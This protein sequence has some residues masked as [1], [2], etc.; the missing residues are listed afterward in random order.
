MYLQ[1]GKT[2]KFLSTLLLLS[3]ILSFFAGF[4][5]AVSATSGD[6]VIDLDDFDDGQ[7]DGSSSGDD[8]LPISIF[9]DDKYWFHEGIRSEG[10][11]PGAKNSVEKTLT[12][13]TE[14]ELGLLAYELYQSNFYADYGWADLD[15]TGWTLKIGNDL[16]LEDHL[17]FPVN[18]GDF[19][20][21]ENKEIV[22]HNY[23]ITFDGQGHTISG[24]RVENAETT[25]LDTVNGQH[26][27]STGMFG[28]LDRSTIC[29]LVLKNP[30]ISYFTFGSSG[31]IHMGMLAGIAFGAQIR[32]VAIDNPII[33][34]DELGSE[35]II[36]SVVGYAHSCDASL[37]YTIGSSLPLNVTI[38]NGVDVY[39]RG[40]EGGLIVGKMN[41][42]SKPYIGGVAGISYN[43][44]ITSCAVFDLPIN[45]NADPLPPTYNICVGGIVGY[46]SMTEE[47]LTGV[48]LLNN[49][50]SRPNITFNDGNEFP[51]SSNERVNVG[52]LAGYIYN[53]SVVN[54]LY[55]GD[56]YWDDSDGAGDGFTT[57]AD[58]NYLYGMFGTVEY[59]E[60][61]FVFSHN[62]SFA[63]CYEEADSNAWDYG[64]G[65]GALY[66]VL[67]GA[68]KSSAAAVTAEHSG[69]ALEQALATFRNWKTGD[70][71]DGSPAV[72]EQ[73][74]YL[75]P[76]QAPFLTREAVEDP[77]PNPTAPTISGSMAM[78]LTEGYE[79][80]STDAYV[81][82]GSGTVTM[83]KTSGDPAI[84][85]NDT[86]KK[87]DIAAGLP[88]GSYL[89]ELKASN[90]TE[91]DATLS[92]TLTIVAANTAPTISGS[93]AMS[94]TE[95]Y[96][97]TSTD[98]YVITGSGTVTMEK[99]SGDSAITWNDST[100]RLD[101]AA[102]LPV[103][104]YLVELKASNGTEP[105]ATLAFTLTVRERTSG[106]GGGGLSLDVKY[107]ANSGA[108]IMYGDSVSSGS[109]YYIRANS[110]TRDGYVF[111]GWNTNA[112]GNGTYYADRGMINSLSQNVELFAQWTAVQT[113]VQP[114]GDPETEEQKE[115]ED[116]QEYS[117]DGTTSGQTPANTETMEWVDEEVPLAALPK[118]GDN[119]ASFCLLMVF[120]IYLVW[121]GS[122][123]LRQY[124]NARRLN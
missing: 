19:R 103:G 37:S 47:I 43:S 80:T 121:M 111:A 11:A 23:N 99:I 15:Y 86:T 95:G 52:G 7:W 116:I 71:P 73:V 104:S 48:C 78:S 60:A 12:I 5:L 39:G 91:P 8:D 35:A 1:I 10:Y 118:T 62:Y 42:G 81:I 45:L 119:N 82:T 30:L 120:A 36:G 76:Y 88:V 53:D 58:N 117:Q 57:D 92:F 85:W 123:W 93:M 77:V 54:N 113:A 20:E 33:K 101:I 110:F 18:L 34:I 3:M 56:L 61:G 69:Y 26:Y 98:A 89:V 64:A 38:I 40:D 6:S 55:F 90:G 44:V 107:N 9:A 14:A 79:A 74:E 49:L 2:R 24:L 102:G 115:D 112:D 59:D 46:S 22:A 87:L 108:G 122:S 32:D 67:N 114:G 97:A 31:G 70:Y 13:N 124:K 16:N 94:L 75:H 66:G 27:Y 100:K 105:D 25:Y 68:G 21:N 65:D 4:P 41:N 17:W 50:S 72:Q 106:G 84:T 29:N 96:E 51:D 63:D 109:D 28:G 83:E